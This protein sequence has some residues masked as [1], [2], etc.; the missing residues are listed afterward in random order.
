MRNGKNRRSMLCRKGFTII[1]LLVVIAIIGVLIA[2]LMPAIQAGRESARRTKCLNNLKQIGLAMQ[3]YQSA[4]KSF[5]PS[6]CWNYVLGN[7]GG[8]FSAQA[9]ILPYIEQ[10][11]IYNFIDFRKSYD[12]NYLPDGSPLRALRVE[13]FLCPSEVNDTARIENGA[14]EN[15]PIN[16]GVNLGT[17]FVFDPATHRGGNGAFFQNSQ[18]TPASFRDGMS[19]TLCAAEVRAFTPFYGGSVPQP[20][21]PMPSQP[22]A[23]CVMGGVANMG[24]NVQEDEGHTEWVDGRTPQTGFTTVFTPNTKVNCTVQGIVHDVDWTTDQEHLPAPVAIYS[25]ITSRSYHPS[26]VNVVMMDGSA[27][28]INDM[29]N[30]QVWQSLSTRQGGEVTYGVP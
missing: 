30:L 26:I 8:D 15:Y 17:W 19:N 24:N 20:L 5:P 6:R 12:D 1:E 14:P 4:L 28:P 25:A 2:L 22:S 13:I 3:N 11:G 18:L 21:T 27:R 29:V 7:D 10:G 16:Y 23:I 9:R